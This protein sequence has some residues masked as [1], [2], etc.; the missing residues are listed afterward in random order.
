MNLLTDIT[1]RKR[2]EEAL[3]ES[4]QRLMDIIDFLPDA[5]LVIDREGK[6]VAWN[7]AIETMTG[8]LTKD[9][10]GKGDYE[11]ALPFY[12]SRRPILI[13]LILKADRDIE[14]RY[15]QIEKKGRVLNGRS[16][17]A[18]HARRKRLPHGQCCCSL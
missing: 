10:I 3:L 8:I 5:T 11:Y 7:K 17:H 16:L 18:Q 4:E 15:D 12:G 13:D 9:M 1:D 14:S 6:V 2:A